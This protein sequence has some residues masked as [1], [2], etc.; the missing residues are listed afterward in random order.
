MEIEEF[1][2]TV[3]DILKNVQ[4]RKNKNASSKDVEN[5]LRHF[6]GFYGSKKEFKFPPGDKK[7]LQLIAGTVTSHLESDVTFFNNKTYL[8]NCNMTSTPFGDV[9]CDI[10]VEH[11]QPKK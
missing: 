4:F 9:F 11:S 7:L 5:M 10:A 8:S 2:K 3:P 6:H 1:A